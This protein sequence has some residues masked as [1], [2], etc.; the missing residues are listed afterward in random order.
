[1]SKTVDQRVVEMRFDNKNFEQNVKTSMN[2]LERLKQSLNF[3]GATKGVENLSTAT[4]N[5]NM[6]ALGTAVES[7]RMKFSALE[8]MGVTAL[9]NITNQA[10]N[11]GKRFASAFTIDPIKTGFQEY[12]TQINA[13]QTILANTQSKGTTLDDVNAALDTLNTYADKTIYN[14][15]EM[16]RNI[17]T[18]TAAGVDLDTSVNAIQGIANLAAVSGSTSQQASTAMYQLSQALASGTVKLMD[19]NSVVNAGMGGEVFQNALKETARVHGVAIDEMIKD[20]GSFRETLSEGWLTSEILTE[21]LQKFTLTTEGLTKAEIERNREMLKS[22]GYTDQQIDDIFKLGQTAT[23]AATKVKTFSQLFDTLKE[24]AQS[25]WTQTWE[26]LVGDFE[27]SKAFLTE[28]SDMFGGFINASS[29]ARNN[30]LSGALGSKWESFTEKI[31]KAGISTEDFTKKLKDVGKEGGV[32]I[33]GLIKRYGS[34]ER[35]FAAGAIPTKLITKTLNKFAGEANNAS[36]STEE[37]QGKLKEFQKVVDEVWQGEF[38]NGEERVE[39]LTKAGYDYAKVQKL[40]NKAEGGRK[41][42]LEDLSEAE[43]MSIGYTKEQAKAIQELAK[44]A[45]EA[46]TPLNELIEDLG[47][48]SGR[49]LLIDS[50][51]NALGGLISVFSAVKKAWVD[52]FPPM[53]SEQLYNIIEAV[54]AFSQHL[55]VGDKTAEN[56]T[57]T[58][59][60]VFA[61]L[62]IILTL[63]TGPIKII[64][65]GVMKV[66]DEMNIDV[67]HY[68]A[69]IGDGLVAVR[70]WVDQHNIF[71]AALRII[72]PYL[73]KAFYGI[74]DWIEGFGEVED[75][76]KYIVE[77]LVNGLKNGATL[78]VQCIVELG[79][80]MIEGFCNLFGIHSPSK[81]SFEWG[82]NIIEGL[83]N[84]IKEFGSGAVD[85]IKNVFSTLFDWVKQIDFGKVL[86]IALGV[87]M[88]F[89]ANKFAKIAAALVNPFG[90]ISGVF[91]SLG[92]VL[93]GFAF[94][95]KANG[96]IKIAAAIAI[97]AASLALLSI[98]DPGRLWSSVGVLAVL[99]GAMVGL[100]ITLS[101]IGPMVAIPAT[102]LAAMAVSIVLL[103]TAINKL[104]SVTLV[105]PVSMI[106]TLTATIVALAALMAACKFLGGGSLKTGFVVSQAAISLLLIIGVVKVANMLTVGE[107][108][109]GAAI[110]AAL[111]VFMLSFALISHI[112]G[113]SI[114]KFGSAMIKIAFFLG[115]MVG[116]IKLISLLEPE[117]V[118]AG[119]GFMLIMESFIYRMAICSRVAGKNINLMGSAML[120]ISLALIAMIGVCKLASMLSAQEILKGVAAVTVLGLLVIGL[121]A[122]SKLAGQHASQAGTMILKISVALL[123]LTGVAF[124]LGQ[125]DPNDLTQG[126]IAIT[127]LSACIA[128]LIAVTKF[129]NATEELNGTL[130]RFAVVIGILG[131]IVIALSLLDPARVL[132]ASASLSAVI[133]SF[134]LLVAMTKFANVSTKLHSTLLVMVIIIGLLAGVVAALSFIDSDKALKSSAALSIVMISLSGM[135]LLVSKASSLSKRAYV[136]IAAMIVVTTAMVGILALLAQINTSVAMS[137]VIALTVLMTALTGAIFVLSK[138][139]TVSLSAVASMATI[140]GVILILAGIL[141]HVKDLDP[142]GSIQHAIA[143][144]ILLGVMTAIL[145]PIVAI[146]ALGAAAIKG[147]AIGALAL[148]AAALIIELAVSLCVGLA[149]LAG[150]LTGFINEDARK[151]I[152]DGLDFMIQVMDKIAYGLGS[153]IGNFMSGF[154]A[155]F[156]SG[157]PTMLDGFHGLIDGIKT[158]AEEAKTIDPS[159]LDGIKTMAEILLILSGAELLNSINRMFGSG[160]F[161]GG[162]L[163]NAF[164][165][166]DSINTLKKLGGVAKEFAKST[167]GLTEEDI[168][169]INLGAQAIKTLAEASNTI[170]KTGGGAW[171]I[172]G[173]IDVENFG[174][175]LTAAATGV[176]SF[177]TAVSGFDASTVETVGFGAQALSKIATASQDIPNT[178]GLMSWICG[179]NDLATFAQNLPIAGAGLTAFVSNLGGFN[180]ES[181]KIAESGSKA[182]SAIAT[183]AKDIPNDGGF[184]GWIVGNNDIASFGQKLP[185]LGSGIRGFVDNLG[186]I[187]ESNVAAVNAGIRILNTLSGLSD[188]LKS[189]TKN[190]PDLGSDLPKFAKKLDEF[191]DKMVD[192]GS[193]VVSLTADNLDKLIATIKKLNNINA[194]HVLSLSK[195]LT[196]I[197]KKGIKNFIEGLTDSDGIANIQKAGEKMAK[198]AIKGVNDKISGIKASG[199]NFATGFANGIRQN[200]GGAVSAAIAMAKKAIA[201][202]KRE[203]DEHSPSRVAYGMGDYFGIGFVNGIV[204]NVSKS[205]LAGEAMANSARDGLAEALKDA[206][207]L[208]DKDMDVQPTIR[209]VIDTSN[210]KTGIDAIASM[211]NLAP[212]ASVLANVGAINASM[213]Q[214]GTDFDDVIDAIRELR[215]DIKNMKTVVN[216]IDG[217][218][219]DDGSNIA[220]AIEQIVR[221]I[222]T[223]RR[224]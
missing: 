123:L 57:R 214:N 40:V 203:T 107:V 77:G 117:E 26:L 198:A 128:G 88:F 142:A 149:S 79:K 91:E 98:V 120:K 104:S 159:S 162:I 170:P 169:R 82:K 24:A 97:L 21:T 119:I 154:G 29:E 32:S 213:S 62:D 2:S 42:T 220:D 200:S 152:M 177:A 127:A 27:E 30:L 131:A 125:I 222:V 13:V 106:I 165:N 90:A 73:K 53:T 172:F 25:G 188:N 22:K 224:R 11:A 118:L 145:K 70:D 8:V 114:S 74:K 92:D 59:K 1:M 112:S 12:E 126:L 210:V 168:S 204:D 202:V 43:L 99:V 146:G 10:V 121:I 122:I 179:D 49:Q 76:P 37:M 183:S 175:G 138:A 14:F 158:L 56:L 176:K 81:V 209:P 135:M 19:W 208:I 78:A 132:I 181:V 45:R 23:D 65:D 66:L 61:L 58:F 133:A 100:M 33:S 95:K 5:V 160:L 156:V 151:Q 75:I 48:P 50:L 9:A 54:N 137:N 102:A 215:D 205:G 167:E 108:L 139:G 153:A 143:L 60:G 83:I 163:G 38:G 41:L 166:D 96:M 103:V 174:T 184:I 31:N 47:K 191:C 216:Q 206:Q 148:G 192:M 6:N 173:D 72:I 18:F 116:V 130:T 39:A 111:T 157:L 69:I 46:G 144:S 7:V 20:Q 87:G 84:G 150:W 63:V 194:D 44:E 71:A 109:K 36:K 164:G 4:K 85:I 193:D 17:G 3:K 171:L 211:F 182:L 86:A 134:S 94:D 35:A 161:G 196:D 89:I 221:A 113:P 199:K 15:T 80:K 187:N 180:D 28:L 124:I 34:L 201:A 178:G 218:T 155:G 147:A 68:T 140:S 219:Y 217:V 52:I 189:L 195:A 105:D 51:K 115:L 141:D 101:K 129:A 64:I 186:S 212:S 136:D 185:T 207:S 223:E 16:T 55:I 93:K 110:M 197:G 67:L 190:L